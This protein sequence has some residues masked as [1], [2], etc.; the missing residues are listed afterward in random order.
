MKLKYQATLVGCGYG[1]TLGM[2]VEGWK[3]AQ[4]QKYVGKVTEPITPVL[5]KDASGKILEEDEFGKLKY[6]TRDLKKGDYTDDTIL[7]V[8]I[9]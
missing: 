6:Y 7:T 1:D 2:S 4:I 5:V 9:A 8:A 3:I